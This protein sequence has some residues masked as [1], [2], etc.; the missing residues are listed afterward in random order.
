MKRDKSLL[1]FKEYSTLIEFQY[2]KLV[3]IFNKVYISSKKNNYLFT[4]NIILDEDKNI[5][6]PLISL[7]SIFKNIKEDTFILSVDTPF[8]NSYI[9]EKLY[10]NNE[11]KFD[12]IVAETVSGIEPLCG[13]YKYSILKE[14]KKSILENRHSL[15]YLLSKL[16]V[17]YIKFD[18]K[19]FINLNYPEDYK[20][21]I[22]IK[23][24]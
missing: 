24:G 2:Q 16:N 9:I 14:V 21:A 12:A 11:S 7:Y 23:L 22:K 4:N 18:E 17:K 19:Y 13:I 8:I 20:K 15:K 1:P 3:K 6:S 5:Y 10:N